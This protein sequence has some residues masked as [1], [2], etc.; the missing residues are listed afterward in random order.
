MPVWN[1][2]VCDTGGDIEHDDTT[3]SVDVV[4]VAETTELLL[5]SGI[6]DIELELTQVLLYVSMPPIS[7]SSKLAGRWTYGGESERVDLNSQSRDVLLL[8]LTS[9]VALDE[10]GLW[11]ECQ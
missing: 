11:Y 10:G 5:T 4:T 7:L 2:L 1:V 6:P 8:E 3:L 9:Q